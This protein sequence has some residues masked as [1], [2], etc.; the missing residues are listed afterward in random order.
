MAWSPPLASL[1]DPQV[2]GVLTPRELAALA[3]SGHRVHRVGRAAYVHGP[4]HRWIFGV[5]GRHEAP[6]AWHARLRAYRAWWLGRG[7]TPARRRAPVAP[8]VQRT[9][10][11]ATL[12][13]AVAAYLEHLAARGDSPHTWRAYR[14]ALRQWLAFTEAS[15]ADW[16]APGRDHLRAYLAY[17]V[18]ARGVSRATEAHRLTI[19]RSFY[20]WCAREGLVDGPPLRGIRGPRGRRRLPRPLSHAQV[21]RLLEGI[22]DTDPL[23]L[24]DRALLETAYA[25]GLRIEELVGLR[26]AD[27]D[28]ERR[29]LRVVGKGDRERECPIGRYAVAALRTY[30]AWGRPDLA[31][32]PD[33]DVVF[34]NA[35]GGPLHQRGARFRFATLARRAELPPGSSPHSLRHSFATHLLEGGADL[36]TIQ[37]LLG[38]QRLVTTAA[39]LQVTPVFAAA[40]YGTAHP[41]ARSRR[42]AAV[43]G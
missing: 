9:P 28:L 17:L 40:S 14:T 8:P 11:I 42:T 6:P 4:G 10:G 3:A 24:R 37:E 30:L 35:R 18:D 27:L 38:H 39:Y 23:A 36:R 19:L 33:P 16:T 15:G 32:T 7:S 41:R 5:W 21:T 12:E 25:A 26:L 1:P 22:T 13:T 29:C 34:L 43:A 20:R 31:A 2:H